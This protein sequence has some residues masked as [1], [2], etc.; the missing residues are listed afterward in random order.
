MKRIL[1]EKMPFE[2]SSEMMDDVSCPICSSQ[3]KHQFELV[4]NNVVYYLDF[5]DKDDL[6]WV[7]PRP[8][9]DYY[10]KL[11]TNLFYNSP[12]PEQF[13]YAGHEE[14]GERRIAKAKKNLDDLESFLSTIEKNSFLEIGCATGELLEEAKNRGWKNLVGNEID[15]TCCRTMRDKGLTIHEGS[16]EDIDLGEQKFDLIFA[17]NVIEHLLDPVSAMNKCSTI[18]SS[19]SLLI[20]RLPDT[21]HPGPLLKLIDHTY[22][23][24][25]VSITKLFE[26]TNYEV[27]DILYSGTYT[28][29]DGKAEIKNMTVIGKRK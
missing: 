14:D 25:R 9:A 5:C 26:K 15:P 29:P 4:I 8:P 1:D 21:Q 16:F 11:Y 6:W 18:Q 24:T 3:G 2:L 17:D 23:F 10:N 19:G 12:C 27:V 13:G 7:N 28:A 22:H 20:F